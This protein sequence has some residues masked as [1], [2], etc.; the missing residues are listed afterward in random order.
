MSLSATPEKISSR[1][2]FIAARRCELY[3]LEQLQTMCEL[4]GNVCQLVHALQKERGYSNLFLSRRQQP[5]YPL[6]A[7]LQD[8]SLYQDLLLRRLLERMAP[9]LGQKA[10]QARLLGSIA[11]VLC[12]LDALQPLRWKIRQQQVDAPAAS[13]AFTRLIA[14]L[15][16]IVFEAANT[17]MDPEITRQLVALFN[18]M[19]G[20]EFS[21]QERATGVIGFMAGHFDDGLRQQ[22]HSL[23]LQQQR[24]L[25]LFRQHAS[26]QLLVSADCL[27]EHDEKLQR[28]REIIRSTRTA[29]LLDTDLAEVWF[30]LCTRRIDAMHLLEQALTDELASQCQ[31][32]IGQCRQALEDNLQANTATR[33]SQNNPPLVGH[34]FS[35]QARPL[36]SLPDD[37]LNESME[38]S[39]LDLLQEQQLLIASQEEALQ[40]ARQ[41]LDERKYIEKAKWLLVKHYHLGEAAAHER[42][43]KA[44]MEKGISLAEVAHQLLAQ[45][46]GAQASHKPGPP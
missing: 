12:R 16:A 43:Q 23:Y 3:G 4:T 10:D 39:M 32:R 34:T 26:R 14:N 33:E 8:Q 9:Q 15:L 37:G 46:A 11:A 6:L 41:A 1:Y 5:H 17:A 20:K 38:K 22:L 25:S 30:E 35:V 42:L 36:D 19:H 18:F 27:Y 31:Q 40:A 44:A 21:G 7:E 2:F 24:S 45:V 13:D 28:L 29:T